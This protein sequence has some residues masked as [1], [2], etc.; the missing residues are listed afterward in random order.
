[1]HG[2]GAVWNADERV[3][4]YTHPLWML[5]HVPLYALFGN[6]YLVTIGLSLACMIAAAWIV[7]RATG[8]ER[9][10]LLFALPLSFSVPIIEY[11][12]S[13]LENPLAMLF[14][15]LFARELWREDKHWLTLSLVS[16]CL[17][18]TRLDFALLIAPTWLW[19][20]IKER[21]T[22]RL[23]HIMLGAM[24][25]L[26]WFAFS[27]WYYGFIFP[28]TKYAKLNTGIPFAEIFTQGLY[29]L[30]ELLV[31]DAF[32]CLALLIIPAFL[33]L[34]RASAS[35]MLAAGI[36]LY[37]LYIITAGGDFMGGRFWSVP[38]FTT[39]LLLARALPP[40]TSPQT[41]TLWLIGLIGLHVVSAAQREQLW[42]LNCTAL[43]VPK[44]SQPK[45]RVFCTIRGIVDERRFYLDYTGLFIAKSGV[46]T[47]AEG[48]WV[49][50]AM[51]WRASPPKK[52]QALSMIGFYGYYAGPEVIIIDAMALAEPLLARLPIQ[53]GAWRV[54]H[55]LRGL[56]EGFMEARMGDLS[57]MDPALARYYEKLRE[58]TSGN[59][60]SVARL[61]T[62][63][64]FQ[65]SE[66]D[67]WLNDYIAR[68]PKEFYTYK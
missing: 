18:L 21:Y 44:Q 48:P 25:L 16:S 56:P 28:N 22:L 27:L 31:R 1:V 13:G 14:I 20:L 33:C 32:S 24:P 68:H 36:I 10:A 11:A 50:E 23:N 2:L 7:I 46:R 35:S 61:G 29:Y 67:G 26:A 54:G 53:A 60:W 49:K 45:D 8:L 41:L 37:S 47:Q 42:Q 65:L 19:L 64:G 52:P 66:Y 5:A 17:L 6:I 38:L 15:A 30:G 4:V 9:S 51:E 12:V 55:Y 63:I 58:V 40:I 62:I 43:D 59:L 57:G 34:Q 39:F 3:Q